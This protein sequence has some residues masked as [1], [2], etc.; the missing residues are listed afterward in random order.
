MSVTVQQ[1]GSEN[2]QT[3]RI[4]TPSYKIDF[5]FSVTIRQTDFAQDVNGFL[6]INKKFCIDSLVT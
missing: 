6:Q 5:S 2:A 1:V 3:C 4:V